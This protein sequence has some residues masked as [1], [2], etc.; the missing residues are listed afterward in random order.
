[1][2]VTN[3]RSEKLLKFFEFHGEKALRLKIQHPKRESNSDYEGIR[4]D[5]RV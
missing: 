5:L 1:M 2:K 4:G 3:P